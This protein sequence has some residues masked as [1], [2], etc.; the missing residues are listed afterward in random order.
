[1]SGIF[2]ID[3]EATLA[4]DP[5]NP[6]ER[7]L[8][9]FVGDNPGLFAG[10]WSADAQETKIDSYPVDEVCVL[11]A[12]TVTLTSADGQVSEF[13]AGDAFAI[14]KG[15]ALTWANTPDV[16]KIYVILDHAAGAAADDS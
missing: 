7:Y 12:G 6:G 4:P 16:R 8:N 9:N 1:M 15:T 14:R 3:P 5:A 13:T 11:L 10:V 2:R